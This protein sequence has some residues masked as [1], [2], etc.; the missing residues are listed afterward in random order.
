MK[1]L[2]SIAIDGPAGAGKSTIAKAVAE[3]L[4]YV[5]VD[6]GA[7]Y[8]ALAVYFLEKGLAPEDEKG[9]AEAVGQAEVKLAY[10][11]GLQH[12]FVNGRDVTGEIRTEAVSAMASASSRYA[13]VRAHLLELQRELARHQNVIMDGR[14]IGTV[15]LPEATLK[16]FLTASP[17]IRA[18]RR[19][20]QLQEQGKLG[21]A[22]LPEILQDIETRDYQDSH[23]AN[24]PLK[25]A[26]DAVLLDSSGLSE[27]E[28]TEQILKALSE[29][30]KEQGMVKEQA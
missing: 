23:R 14:D 3:R 20:V 21:E 8:R 29:K 26:E 30:Q 28:V 6:T 19:Y 16:V 12:V 7:M 1:G 27:A 13:A 25:A 11:D 10:Q 9:I 18:E 5:Y 24:A 15:V 2:Y 22:T 17:R 4:S